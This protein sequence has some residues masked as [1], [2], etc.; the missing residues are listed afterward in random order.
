MPD[1]DLN[2]SIARLK[3]RLDAVRPAAAEALSGLARWYDVELTYS[4]NAIEGNTLTHSETA[5]VIEQ[6]ITI[7]GKPLIH[8]NEAIDHF[9]AV[10]AMRALA[11]KKRPVTERDVLHL[12]EIVLRRSRPAVAG[13][14]AD[15]P[16]RIVGSATILPPAH[17]LPGLMEGFGH[18]LEAMSGWDGAF[19]AHYGL[20]DIHPFSDGNGRTARLLMNLMLLRDG[21]PPVSIGPALKPAYIDVLERRH[22][23][24]PLGHGVTDA[25]ARSAYRAFMGGRLVASLEDHL[26]F[27]DEG[28]SSL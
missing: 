4:S 20:V 8:H 22:L 16:R 18:A 10:Q 5:L 12:H 28:R 13:R 9:A 11:D 19:E 7:A 21:Y 23:A 27:L 2:Q 17:K 1:G 14:Y 25:G 15:G 26:H 3:A 6:G 24:E